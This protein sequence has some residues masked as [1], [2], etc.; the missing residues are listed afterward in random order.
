MS[1]SATDL[2]NS[3]H[4]LRQQ[5]QHYATDRDDYV[6]KARKGL[7]EVIE[8]NRTVRAK[9]SALQQHVEQMQ[10]GLEKLRKENGQ[11]PLFLLF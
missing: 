4:D 5:S 3:V 11:S 7:A 9:L 2:S 8:P 6:A 10:K 1:A